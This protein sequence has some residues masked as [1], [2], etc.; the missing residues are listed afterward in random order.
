MHTFTL[1]YFIGLYHTR[2]IMKIK[3]NEECST[4]MIFYRKQPKELWSMT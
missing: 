1:Y 4:A 2:P 3:Y